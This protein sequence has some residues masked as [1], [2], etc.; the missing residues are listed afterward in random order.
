MKEYLE[1]QA[2]GSYKLVMRGIVGKD[3]D[4]EVPEGAEIYTKNDADGNVFYRKG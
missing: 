3:D 2:D 1:K 4:I